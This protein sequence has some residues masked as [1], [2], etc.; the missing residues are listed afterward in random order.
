MKRWAWVAALLAL[1]FAL[2]AGAG[3]GGAAYAQ[4][5]ARG[6][7][8]YPVGGFRLVPAVG[9]PDAG[10][11]TAAR[12]GATAAG[13]GGS[14]L[15]LCDGA[16]TWNAVASGGGP[17]VPGI[18]ASGTTGPTWTVNTDY[19]AEDDEDPCAVLRGGDAAA[20]GETG[21][22]FLSYWCQTNLGDGTVIQQIT[23]TDDAAAT[24]PIVSVGEFGAATAPDSLLVLSAGDGTNR[25]FNIEL[26]TL[27]AVTFGSLANIVS[28]AFD[29]I[30][31]FSA[32]LTVNGTTTLNDGVELGAT[33]VD[34]ISFNG[35]LD[36]N[37]LPDASGLRYLGSAS[38][39][40]RVVYT[41]AVQSGTGL[42]LTLTGTGGLWN[43][44]GGTGTVYSST[45]AADSSVQL[46]LGKST[47]FLADTDVDA[48]LHFRGHQVGDAV[49]LATTGLIRLDASQDEMLVEVPSGGALR[50]GSGDLIMDTGDIQLAALA[51]VDGRDVSVDGSKLDGIETGADVTDATN[52]AAAGAVMHSEMDGTLYAFPDAVWED[53][54]DNSVAVS[55]PSVLNARKVTKYTANTTTQDIATCGE[56]RLPDTTAGYASTAATMGYVISS[57]T[58]T[59]TLQAYRRGTDTTQGSPCAASSAGSSGTWASVTINAATLAATCTAAPG[60]ELLVCARF[61]GSTSG[62]VAYAGRAQIV[63]TH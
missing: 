62:A 5:V 22:V 20:P 59:I 40:F 35:V 1:G 60:T 14:T 63:V 10:L 25:M 3:L 31:T 21:S 57:G 58:A 34:L 38:S 47:A 9:A 27:G 24:S 33:A 32:G 30:T 41:R 51:Q 50:V 16:G 18:S 6:Q 36:T 52:V 56:V 17:G 2:L 26:T 19:S 44:S 55:Y 49:G 12:A 8:T 61:D 43:L 4:T 37:L 28:F 39:E 15:Y 11:C 45:G 42:L 54:A 23:A 48:T 29:T 7:E 53:G 46:T 13:D